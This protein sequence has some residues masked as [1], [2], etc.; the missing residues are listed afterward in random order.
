[1]ARRNPNAP[2]VIR[3]MPWFKYWSNK[4][5]K[6]IELCTEKERSDVLLAISRYATGNE[7]LPVL[8]GL[9]EAT[10]AL[11]KD[12][13]DDSFSSYEKKVAGGKNKPVP[14]DS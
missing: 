1:M 6:L 14:E 2:V 11:M 8:T 12:D 9:A 3:D 13:I 10:F 5:H 7:N 4:Y